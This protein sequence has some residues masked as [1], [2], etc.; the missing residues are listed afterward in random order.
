MNC[1]KKSVV[2]LLFGASSRRTLPGAFSNCSNVIWKNA[3]EKIEE[4]KTTKRDRGKSGERGKLNYGEN[5]AVLVLEVNVTGSCHFEGSSTSASFLS[6][7]R[8]L[9][10]EETVYLPTYIRTHI[11]AHTLII[12]TAIIII[13][14]IYVF[15]G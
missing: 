12:T 14:I 9:A 4:K 6:I 15:T 11:Y 8:S 10:I 3:R 13:T 5:I 2:N 7:P 1:V